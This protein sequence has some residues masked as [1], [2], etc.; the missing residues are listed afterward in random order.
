MH[1]HAG[2][3]E[4]VPSGQ[5][6]L[7]TALLDVAVDAYPAF[8]LPPDSIA[9]PTEDISF[10]LSSLIH[11]HPQAAVFSEAALRDPVIQR[12]FAEENEHTGRTAMIYRNT[13]TGSGAQLSMMP[14]TLL[15]A[16]WRH[17][18]DG[19]PSTGALAV[20]A[21]KELRLARDVLAGKRRT[22]LAKES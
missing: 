20:E 8:L 6:D 22:I 9:V 1:E 2:Q 12:V 17:L 7:E 13:G 11:H 5:D 18:R 14:E 19:N 16:A 21:I 3:I 15:R 4:E 10:R